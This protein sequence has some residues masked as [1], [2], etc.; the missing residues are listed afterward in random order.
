MSYRSNPFLPD[1]QF[2]SDLLLPLTHQS[3]RSLRS[4]LYTGDSRGKSGEMT[5]VYCRQDM[6][7]FREAKRARECVAF[8]NY[9]TI[10]QSSFVIT[11]V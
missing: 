11:L 10:D 5:V 4:I 2:L 7:H 8:R 6:A 1:D 3:N 9:R